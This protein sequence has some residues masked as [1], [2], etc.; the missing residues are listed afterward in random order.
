MTPQRWFTLYAGPTLAA[1]ALTLISFFLV[2]SQRQESQE[3]AENTIRSAARVLA[4]QVQSSFDH[5]DALILSVGQRYQEAASQG[6]EAL[7]RLTEQVRQEVPHYPLV[8]RIG[9]VNRDGINFFNTGFTKDTTERPSGANRAYFQRARAGE[10]AL[11]FEG[12]VEALYG[13]EWSLILA[14]RIDDA[15]GQFL[16]VV[17]AV[18][19]TDEMAASFA[20]VHIGPAGIINL[21]GAD[22]AQIARLPALSGANAGIGNRNVSQAIRELMRAQPGQA[23]YV[24]TTT[25]PID[26]VERLYTY[27][28]L[29]HAP[30][31][32]TVGTGTAEF[33]AAWHQTAALLA[34][35]GTPITGLLFWSARRLGRQQASLEQDIQDRT[36][37]LAE[38]ERFFRDLTDTL[39]S[40]ISYWTDELRCSF[41]NQ[42]FRR[43]W[44]G[45]G[46]EV[47]SEVPGA[48]LNDL[49]APEALAQEQHA[50]AQALRGQAQ[51]FER[52]IQPAQGPALV[53]LV[54]LTPDVL[55]GRVQGL[56]EQATDITS[57][58][59]AEDE[60]RR[61][62]D[63]LDDLYHR[64]PCGYHSLAPDGTILK[65]NDTELRWL[66]YS[67]AE[68]G[69][70]RN[71]REF[72]TAESQEI[73]AHTFPMVMAQGGVEELQVV[74]VRQ[75]GSTFPALLSATV[76]RDASGQMTATRS[77]LIDISQLRQQQDNLRRALAAAPMAVRVAGLHD[78][79]VLFMNRAF[80]DLVH[81]D[82]AQAM[83][84]DIASTYVDPAVFREIQQALG[85]G[86][87]VLNKLVHLHLQD[88]PEIDTV[89]ALGSYMVI[90]Y[91]GQPAV[92]AWLYDV[93]QLHDARARAEAANRAKSAFLANMSHEIR[94]PMN[95]IMGLNHLLLRDETDGLQRS[96]LDKVNAAARHLLQVINDI[97]DLSKIESGRMTLER[98][99][100]SVDEVIQRAIEMVRARADDKRLE[101]IVDTDHLPPRLLGDPTR[102]SQ[103]LINLL[104]NA[105]K[106]TPHGWVALRG[107]LVAESG[108]DLQVHFEVQDTGP[109]IAPDAHDKLF[110]AFE[111]G[112]ASTTRLHGG[113]GL[114][115]ALTRHF[116]ELM[117][118]TAGVS[119]APGEGS[120]FWFTAW[121]ERATDSTATAHTPSLRGLHALLV[122]DLAEAR[123]SVSARL[124][125]LGLTVETCASG[126]EALTLVADRAAGG[127][128]FDLL[129][130]DWQ[131]APIDGVETLR[132]L[133]ELLGAGK[134]PVALVSAY[135]DPQLWR[136]AREAGGDMV[137]LKPLTGTTLK[138]GLGRLLQRE[139]PRLAP[140]PV[141]ATEARVRAAFQ[142]RRVLLVEDNPINQEVAVALLE[143]AGVAVDTCDN[144]QEAVEQAQ[145]QDYAL[146]LMDV[147]MPLMDGLEATRLIRARSGTALPIIAMTA[148]AFGEDQEACLE[149]GMNDHLAKPVD[150]EL[151]FAA[152]LRWLPSHGTATVQP[153]APHPT[154]P[155]TSDGTDAPRARPLDERLAELPG[156]SLAAGL[157]ATRGRMDMLVKVLRSFLGRYRAG[158][159]P[160]REAMQVRDWAAAL[161][162]CHDIRG[163]CATVGALSLAEMAH[164]IEVALTQ[165]ADP[166]VLRNA[167]LE[168]QRLQEALILLTEQMAL[169]L[170]V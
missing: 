139:G 163:A 5:A 131:M 37:S 95:A 132:H 143:A 102:L 134:P 2:L 63:E 145:A 64:A 54:T 149:A 122:D 61:Q 150:P 97:L 92:L 4:N 55:N 103:M 158:D 135:D 93:T 40:A 84:M 136:Q 116:S 72:L 146:V 36:R 106:F 56:F 53:M 112:D 128:F 67:R 107:Q 120:T 82:E 141:G 32:M 89:W 57:Q 50:Y 43:T 35:I 138:D 109:G 124:I 77:A 49:L 16:G 86:E 75:D 48:R 25:A 73:F 44:A 99:N 113:T 161:K 45:A 29:H 140:E 96:R 27:Q 91:D 90:D 157:A 153:D 20:G 69:A 126:V 66:G 21:R 105:V 46:G 127:R 70:Q 83:G 26:G 1:L 133:T 19:P 87:M 155:A 23:H 34:L 115:L 41:A 151:L 170:S 31:W 152:L 110:Q 58:K 108:R 68:F 60:I 14:R 9:I 154:A 79:R 159:A 80:C 144:G 24:Y 11:M 28:K 119:S 74:F 42:A 38:S 65:I 137:L 111:Q 51:R 71:I 162:C 81:R 59:K 39:P 167:G 10:H 117:G 160:L 8:K 165:S 121:L 125:E 94:T 156:Y 30:F 12:P 13:K 168:A 6:P 147:Q 98:R 33:N 62:A 169:E 78:N 166:T 118:G 76:I 164:G 47:H 100:F 85:R 130:I 18:L 148:D 52:Q 17:F 3:R 101:L 104:S 88:R 114:G 123:E 15:S 129:I 142:G 22:F 7:A